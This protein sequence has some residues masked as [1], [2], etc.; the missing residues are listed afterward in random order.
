MAVTST[1]QN[2]TPW[3]RAAVVASLTHPLAGPRVGL[4]QLRAPG[5]LWLNEDLAVHDLKF[6]D[7]G[8][9]LDAYKAFL[10][11][12]CS[13]RVAGAGEPISAWGIADRY[14]GNGLNGNGGAGRATL[15][16]GYYVKGVGRTP[17]IGDTT[18]RSHASGDAYLEEATRE[19]IFGEL[20]AAELP[21]GAVRTLAIIDIGEQAYWPEVDKHETKVLVIRLPFARVGHFVRALGH[22]CLAERAGI[23]DAARVAH[24]FAA[25]A[26]EAGNEA[27]QAHVSTLVLRVARQLGYCFVHRLTH[28]S[29]T[30]SNI[31][32]DGRLLDFGASSSV[33]SYGRAR[34][35]PIS[36]GISFAGTSSRVVDDLREFAMQCE[37]TLDDATIDWS[38]QI[39]AAK[40]AY[41]HEVLLQ[42][43][44][45]CG[46]DRDV[47]ADRA[48][49][50]SMRDAVS[51][52]FRTS[53]LSLVDLLH[54]GRRK[55]WAAAGS[56]ELPPAVHQALLRHG[57]R[58]RADPGPLGHPRPELC[59]EDMRHALYQEVDGAPGRPR[60]EAVCEAI[61]RWVARNRRDFGAVRGSMPT[62]KPRR[63]DA[64][65]PA[66]HPT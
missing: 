41:E 35:S 10:L 13:Y 48:S 37:R 63:V 42:T 24:H 61:A 40:Q 65:R 38:A 2:D 5:L 34:L 47:R 18:D 17:L 64:P 57:L 62:D 50:S 53:S 49:P 23:D 51:S 7:Y 27:I 15:I 36:A 1:P 22:R 29:P 20:F 54:E 52:A 19:A 32:L 14:G 21:F 56:P 3:R 8:E 44:R 31:A 46:L 58:P 28:G 4:R 25:W 12:A 9:D 59:R 55:A 26:R 39:G 6:A 43:L 66:S 45:L 30:L 33:P 11:E 60:S 16:N